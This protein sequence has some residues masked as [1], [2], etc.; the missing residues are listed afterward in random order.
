[1]LN[2][3]SPALGRDFETRFSL[4]F[5]TERI[6]SPWNTGLANRVSVI[7]KLPIVVPSVVSPTD[8]PMTSPSVKRLFT[9]R[10]SYC[11]FAKLFV[12]MERLR[13]MGQGTKQQIIR[14]ATVRVSECLNSVPISNCS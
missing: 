8:T 13:V 14:F 6:V 5:V 12:K 1:M 7:P 9:M 3:T 10:C 2:T 4:T 11:F